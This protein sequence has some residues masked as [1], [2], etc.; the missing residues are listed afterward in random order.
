MKKKLNPSLAKLS[1][2]E[3]RL[4]LR[5]SCDKCK[6]CCYVTTELMEIRVKRV[7]FQRLPRKFYD[8]E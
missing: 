2:V 4:A 8:M 3:R 1:D 6:Y 5:V 7:N